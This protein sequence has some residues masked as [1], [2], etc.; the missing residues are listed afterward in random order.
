M[1]STFSS[2]YSYCNL[3]FSEGDGDISIRSSWEARVMM[4][5][6]RSISD[7]MFLSYDGEEEEEEGDSFFFGV[8]FGID[9][10]IGSL[11]PLGCVTFGPIDVD[12]SLRVYSLLPLIL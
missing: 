8:W 6:I 4:S 9:T 5:S 10:R 11:D 7:E 2:S 3:L 1:I 12:T